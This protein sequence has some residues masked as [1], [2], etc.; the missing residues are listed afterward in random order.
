M[1]LFKSFYYQRNVSA[2]SYYTGVKFVEHFRLLFTKNFSYH[3]SV[4][5]HHALHV[6]GGKIDLCGLQ[7]FMPQA[8]ADDGQAGAHVPQDAG[9][10]M[11]PRICRREW[12][13]TRPFRQFS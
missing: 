1:A 5:F 3:F 11:P 8:F 9:P 13:V 7:T 12:P 4:G 2:V 6:D 10:G